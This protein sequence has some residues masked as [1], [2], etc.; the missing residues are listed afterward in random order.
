MIAIT[1]DGQTAYVADDGSGTVTVINTTT[2]TTEKTIKVGNAPG[3]I[4]VTP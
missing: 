4:V 2:N 1:P 3:A